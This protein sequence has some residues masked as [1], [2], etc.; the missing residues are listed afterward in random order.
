[1][2]RGRG[3]ALLLAAVL[4]A[5]LPRPVASPASV[6]PDDRP[7]EK[8]RLA[9]RSLL[10]G[11]ARAG[12]RLVAVGE[13]GHI[14]LSDDDGKSWRQAEVP[15]HATL[16]AVHFPDARR[17]WAV[18]H[19]AV[20][21]HTEDGGERWQRQYHDPAR[22]APLLDVWFRGPQEGYAIGAY[23]LF[24]A[25]RDGGKTWRKR[26][27]A[28][29]DFHL[30]AL[31]AAPDGRLFIAGEAG[32]LYRSDDGGWSWR[33]LPSPYAGS[34]FGI[35]APG[36]GRVLVFGL[37]GKLFRSEDTGATWEPVPSG[38]HA[39]LQGGAV[40]PD[41]R[42][43]IVGLGGAVLISGD[44]GRTFSASARPDRRGIATLLPA[45]RH[46]LVLFGESGV[47]Q[48]ALGPGS[49]A[50]SRRPDGRRAR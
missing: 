7:V 33:D 9:A 50:I 43:V 49:G 3:A 39:S 16:T 31:A 15:T 32:H 47:S 23:G 41:G 42:I 40:L 10:L 22:E 14:L 11:A 26:S 12:S 25:T 4:V 29:E 45:D 34:Y 2:I 19:D 48:H 28:E 1:V 5:G 20:I 46:A 24:L 44:W 6:P 17:G 18:G 38:T 21:L 35:L 37:R 30:N 13:R 36:R 27:I 8:A